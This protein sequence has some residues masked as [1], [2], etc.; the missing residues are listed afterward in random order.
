M[1]PAEIPTSAPYARPINQ[2][3]Q[4]PARLFAGFSVAL[5]PSGRTGS[6]R[7]PGR[8]HRE[9]NGRTI[10]DGYHADQRSD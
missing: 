10:K 6:E 3:G 7:G 8:F 4:K 9:R 5:T 2:A 1:T